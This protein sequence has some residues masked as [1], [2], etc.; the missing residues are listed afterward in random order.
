MFLLF[1]GAIGSWK[2]DFYFCGGMLM[3]T[4]IGALVAI[5]VLVKVFD[6]KNMVTPLQTTEGT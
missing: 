4:A 3:F 6:I 5:V 1:Q 2:D